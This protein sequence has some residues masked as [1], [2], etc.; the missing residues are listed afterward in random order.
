MRYAMTI[1][2]LRD[3]ITRLHESAAA[4]AALGVALDARATGTPLGSELEPPIGD[5][6]AALGLREALAVAQPS[7]LQPL[8]AEIRTFALTNAKL[9][10]ASSRAC[11]W[12][13]AEPEILHA[14][15]DVSVAVAR[16]LKRL[17]AQLP[18]LT[19]RLHSPGSTFLDIGVGVAALSIEM[20]RLWPTLRVV[21]I[22]R[23]APA[24]A[25]GRERVGAAD[26]ADRIVLREQ[27]AEELSDRDAFDLA[28]L[29]GAFVSQDNVEALV[30]RLKSALRPRGWLLLAIL[31]PPAE[32]D[33]LKTALTRL[34]AAMF[35][36]TATTAE[37][38]E[39][40]LTRQ[41]FVDVRTLPRSPS[42]LTALVAGRRATM[43]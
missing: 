38:I 8:L 21:G 18:G 24:I 28:W 25:L 2:I 9:L 3:T 12:A 40:L 33:A 15:G 13:H 37:T 27:S 20:A 26:L 32:G 11:G 6:V 4:L 31:C 43:S 10:F 5:I 29:P 34:R 14:A 39:A 42:S 22:D 7:D 17:S 36:G 35:G 30:G 16:T 19:E 1:D 23:L 41:G